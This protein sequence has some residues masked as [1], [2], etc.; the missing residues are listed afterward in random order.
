MG[1]RFSFSTGWDVRAAA[2]ASRKAGRMFMAA[3]LVVALGLPVA[4]GTASAGE[5]DAP[6]P[7]DYTGEVGGYQ[8]LSE[9]G[10]LPSSS[11][12]DAVNPPDDVRHNDGA[13]D[14]AAVGRV[15]DELGNADSGEAFGA[16]GASEDPA[17]GDSVEEAAGV[18]DDVASAIDLLADAVPDGD[19]QERVR[20]VNRWMAANVL[21]VEEGGEGIGAADRVLAAEEA[22]AS[23]R[24]D[25]AAIAFTFQAV[26]DKLEIPCVCVQTP[27]GLR[28]WNLVQVEDEWLHVDVAANAKA[29]AACDG[30]CAGPDALPEGDDIETV[31]HRCLEACC[32]VEAAALNLPEEAASFEAVEGFDLPQEGADP[33][34]SAAVE[35]EG[36]GEA[37]A[38]GDPEEE[39]STFEGSIALYASGW[40]WPV[41]GRS[42]ISCKFGE[43]VSTKNGKQPH[44]AIDIPAPTGTPVVAARAGT[45]VAINMDS[46]YGNA[47]AI[48]HDGGFSTFYC[49]LNSRAVGVGASV[50][51]GQTIGYV[52]NTGISSGPHLHFRLNTNASKSNYWGSKQNPLNYVSYS[53]TPSHTHSYPVTGYSYWQSYKHGVTYG[54]CSCGATKATD[55]EN[56]DFQWHGLVNKCTKCSAVYDK[57]AAVMEYFTNKQTT[58]YQGAGYGQTALKTIPAKTVL[59]PLEA[60]RDYAAGR[61]QMKVTYGGVTGYVWSSDVTPNMNGGV[62]TWKNG[63]CTQCGVKQAPSATG[64]YQITADKTLYLANALRGTQLKLKAGDTIRV[65][66][67]ETTTSGYLWGWTDTGYTLEMNYDNMK[68]QSGDKRHGEAT[69]VPE[70]VYL[71]RAAANRYYGLDVYG[72]S[73]DRG[74]NIQLWKDNGSDAQKFR[75]CKN[76][77]GTYTI[78]NI[79]SNKA[80]D[81]S[82]WSMASGAN[83]G[84]WDNN[85]GANQR[86]YVERTKAGTYAF[87]NKNS[88]LYLDIAG[89]N[90]AENGNIQQYGYGDTLNQQFYLEPVNKGTLAQQVNNVVSITGVSSQYAFTGA[91]VVPVPTVRKRVYA[92]EALR[93]P[94]S[95]TPSATSNW[96][97]RRDTV[98]LKAGRTYVLEVGA[99]SHDAGSG[100]SVVALA[101]DF[102]ADKTVAPDMVF[103]YSTKTQYKTFTPSADCTLIFYSG[104]NGACGGNVSTWKNIRVYETLKSG[105]DYKVSY[106]NNVNAGKAT[107]SVAGLGSY[108]DVRSI[109]FTISAKKATPTV[110][111][112]STSYTYDGKAKKP[113]VTVKVGATKLASGKDYTVSYAN[114]VKVGT[115]TVKV[116]L[117]GNYS[118]SASKSFTIKDKVPAAPA[119][120][121][122][123]AKSPGGVWYYYVSGNLAKGW[124][125]VGGTWYYLDPTT[126]AMATGWKKVGGAWYYL[127]DWGGMAQGWARVGGK[128]YYLEPGSGA[129][130]TGWKRVGGKW[131]YLE[132][133]G[134]MAE[135]WK[136]LGGKW[137]YL[138][139][140][141]GAMQTGWYMVGD[142][143][144]YSGGSGA[145]LA[146]AWVD[147]V[148]WVGASGAMATSSWV[149][150]GR[151]WVGADGRW[152]G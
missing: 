31:D 106:S 96:I 89:G 49:H 58:L 34:E 113:S 132:G 81:V 66:K 48:L 2:E 57:D 151:Y 68:Y 10:V 141:S 43:L 30:S 98:N 125:N 84:Q 88:N 47:I 75:F 112:S 120:K 69:T 9:E 45:V 50:Q 8:L 143:W 82:N 3:V 55:Y 56:H 95:G 152:A 115:A 64:T 129:M 150:A 74:A 85:N 146:N 13:E 90:V 103:S 127:K 70:G 94:V 116:T 100:S 32:L 29:Y 46:S 6:E 35:D 87:R 124:K 97:Y 114:N 42:T 138:R 4:P 14:E 67:V 11:E 134:S 23:G 17:E 53:S 72:A 107:L 5:A 62:H 131:Y 133:S 59:K 18:L 73:T 145:M 149:D 128:W 119:S 104:K 79:R 111:L 20:S 140:G 102:T 24:G 7:A 26:M 15:D 12:V 86:W 137:Y 65:T 25:S 36:Q 148:Y 92:A 117:K 19:A 38:A 109:P 91:S 126:G 142:A 101:Y 61:F 28:V 118:G 27:D 37:G 135:G 78:V 71:I 144:Y 52:G 93:V 136:K 77:D 22:L 41:P 110:S 60:P 139:P 21:L 83:V 76:D 54:K 105:V 39:D 130:A 63:A 80:L 108:A 123:W 33:E 51:A 99:I 122:G 147:G 44:E 16:F 121:S 1:R 40:T